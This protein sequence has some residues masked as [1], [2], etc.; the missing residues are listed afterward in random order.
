MTS[1]LRLKFAQNGRGRARHSSLRRV[2]SEERRSAEAGIPLKGAV[3][4][5]DQWLYLVSSD[6]SGKRLTVR[7]GSCDAT[8]TINVLLVSGSA[9]AAAAEAAEPAPPRGLST[10]P[11]FAQVPHLDL[12]TNGRSPE[13]SAESPRKRT[14]ASGVLPPFVGSFSSF[15]LSSLSDTFSYL[16]RIPQNLYFKFHGYCHSCF[17]FSDN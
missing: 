8:E 9:D 13:I 15:R 11:D 17:P 4:S 3:S 1:C 7:V 16:F 6:A 5:Q 14:S 12:N 2:L 10:R